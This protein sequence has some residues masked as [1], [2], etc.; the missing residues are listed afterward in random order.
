VC[1]LITDSTF[2]SYKILL[3]GYPSLTAPDRSGNRSSPVAGLTV[4]LTVGGDLTV[5]GHH[6]HYVTIKYSIWTWS[7]VLLT[8][9]LYPRAA[10]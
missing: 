6:L 9:R 7:V 5:G 8:D 2:R 4:G 1:S 10:R 3:P